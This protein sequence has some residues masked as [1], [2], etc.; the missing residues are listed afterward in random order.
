MA[1]P[2]VQVV[3]TAERGP[4]GQ[5]GSAV[6]LPDVQVVATAE[7]GLVGRGPDG[8]V[9]SAVALPDVQVVATAERGRAEDQQTG[10]LACS[11]SGLDRRVGVPQ[12]QRGERSAIGEYYY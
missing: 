2:D 11:P 5:F 8:Q 10:D 4:D 3:A 6:T 9:E 7:R 1:L 12:Y